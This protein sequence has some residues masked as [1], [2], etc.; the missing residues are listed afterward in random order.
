[1]YLLNKGSLGVLS[2]GGGYAMPPENTFLTGKRTRDRQITLAFLGLRRKAR[3]T[4]GGEK[5]YADDLIRFFKIN[6][7]NGQSLADM[8]ATLELSYDE[9]VE[10][11]I[12]LRKRIRALRKERKARLLRDFAWN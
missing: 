5:V 7:Q 1:M 9:I 12:I 2:M 4:L 3:A 6:F 8:A 11:S 10:L